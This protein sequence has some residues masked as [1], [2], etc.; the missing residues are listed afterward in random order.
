MGRLWIGQGRAG[1]TTKTWKTRSLR[2][3]SPAF[4]TGTHRF[5]LVACQL[6]GRL[7]SVPVPVPGS[8][9]GA[10]ELV[11]DTHETK[12]PTVVST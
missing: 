2:T 11:V 12:H 4:V 5:G 6:T 3:T 10:G 9:P 8:I 7:W 1:S